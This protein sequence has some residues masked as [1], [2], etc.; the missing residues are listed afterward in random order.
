MQL[1]LIW[2]L[3]RAWNV[4]LFAKICW[5][6]SPH[7]YSRSS[8]E[9]L[10]IHSRRWAWEIDW[11]ISGR[12]LRTVEASGHQDLKTQ[13]NIFLDH[14]GNYKLGLKPSS[15]KFPPLKLNF[16]LAETCCW[17]YLIAGKLM[18]LGSANWIDDFES[19]SRSELDRRLTL[20]R[21]LMI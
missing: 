11:A 10:E 18:R 4:D 9:V 21:I 8:L 13:A 15:R 19:K 5:V 12:C 17:K 7:P 14:F 2:S 6:D 3:L 16:W 1:K 20:I